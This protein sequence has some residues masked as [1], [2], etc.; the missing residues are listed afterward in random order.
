MAI[1]PMTR[2]VD[3]VDRGKRIECYECTIKRFRTRK[4]KG[5]RDGVLLERARVTLAR[6]EMHLAALHR[7]FSHTRARTINYRRNSKPVRA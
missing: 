4:R 7:S 1:R 3:D 2:P 5:F 6:Q